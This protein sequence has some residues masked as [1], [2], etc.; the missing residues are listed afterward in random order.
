METRS[1]YKKRLEAEREDR[2]WWYETFHYALYNQMRNDGVDSKKHYRL[3]HCHECGLRDV[4]I[5]TECMGR[6]FCPHLH[7]YCEECWGKTV[8][9]RKTYEDDGGECLSVSSFNKLP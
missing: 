4:C 1:R 8:D 5:V 6:N 7:I 3:V 2:I 9:E